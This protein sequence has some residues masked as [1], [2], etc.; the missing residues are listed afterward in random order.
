MDVGLNCH[1]SISDVVLIGGY[2][3]QKTTQE[4][5]NSFVPFRRELASSQ[6]LERS[7]QPQELCL[8]MVDS[9]SQII[10]VSV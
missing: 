7:R 3:E 9:K 4:F 1:R 5:L 2:F 10:K 6:S 8:K